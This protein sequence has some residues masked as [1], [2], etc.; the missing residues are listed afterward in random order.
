MVQ[1]D[2]GSRS[3]WL[4]QDG[5]GEDLLGEGRAW[6]CEG[7]MLGSPI[8]KVISSL[9]GVVVHTCHPCTWEEEAG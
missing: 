2:R 1:S 3:L 4:G 5:G 9:L 6:G 7:Q 8:A